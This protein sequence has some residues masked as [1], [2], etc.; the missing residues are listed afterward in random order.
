MRHRE[1]N[2]LSNKY[3]FIWT[4][5]HPETGNIFHRMS[6]QPFWCN[7]ENKR[8]LHPCLFWARKSN[9]MKYND[10]CLLLGLPSYEF[11]YW[12]KLSY[13]ISRDLYGN[14]CPILHSGGTPKLSLCANGRNGTKRPLRHSSL[15]CELRSMADVLPLPMLLPSSFWT[16]FF[17]LLRCWSRAS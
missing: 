6:L 15:L 12:K 2:M 9:S 5:I 8:N 7:E 3:S 13:K 4:F 11:L 14:N 10:A 17:I 16:S 1:F